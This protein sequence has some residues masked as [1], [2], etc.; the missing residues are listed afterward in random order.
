MSTRLTEKPNDRSKS[1]EPDNEDFIS[2]P[3]S[4]RLD[5]YLSH[6]FPVQHIDESS[7]SRLLLIAVVPK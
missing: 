4:T 3:F 1:N 6:I 5:L 7:V 2:S